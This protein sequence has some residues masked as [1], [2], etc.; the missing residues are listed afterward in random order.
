MKGFKQSQ[1]VDALS[2]FHLLLYL[3]T[4][5]TVAMRVSK[6]LW[7]DAERSLVTDLIE[8]HFKVK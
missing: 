4:N 5:D 7:I 3:A 2:D 8:K 1:L 6:D